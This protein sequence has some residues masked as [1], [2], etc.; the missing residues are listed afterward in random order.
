MRLSRISAVIERKNHQD[1]KELWWS[2]FAPQNVLTRTYT[3]R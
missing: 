3:V 1:S 2:T